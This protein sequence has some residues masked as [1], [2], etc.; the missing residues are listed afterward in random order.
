MSHI[1]EKA[2]GTKKVTAQ[3]VSRKSKSH[4]RLVKQERHWMDRILD[5][6]HHVAPQAWI[7]PQYQHLLKSTGKIKSALH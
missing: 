4:L 6:F 7:P 5:S 3:K 2:K 1:K